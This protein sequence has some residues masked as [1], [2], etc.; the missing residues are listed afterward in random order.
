MQP[1]GQTAATQYRT[2][3]ALL[4]PMERKKKPNFHASKA[5]RKLLMAAD[6]EER[7]PGKAVLHLSSTALKR[8]A[9][10]LPCLPHP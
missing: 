6:W 7:R 10:G 3:Y 2:P 4:L 1:K 9:Q 5:G 8:P